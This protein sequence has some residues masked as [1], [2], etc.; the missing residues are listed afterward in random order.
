MNWRKAIFLAAPSRACSCHGLSLRQIRRPSG[1]AEDA[2]E[3]YGHIYFG[4]HRQL[5]LVHRVSSTERRRSS[6]DW[7]PPAR[8][9]SG[10]RRRGERRA[11]GPAA[12]GSRVVLRRRRLLWRGRR[13]PRHSSGR[14]RGRA[15]RPTQASSFPIRD[16]WRGSSSIP[17][18]LNNSIRIVTNVLV[19]NHP[20]AKKKKNEAF[21]FWT[22]FVGEKSVD[23]PVNI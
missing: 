15:R 9:R 4:R 21:E 16:Y 2:P 19:W 20:H 8:G 17:T 13:P 6:R 7:E 5:P 10:G 3:R 23:F 18:S 1:G 14:E 22:I 11:K 12:A